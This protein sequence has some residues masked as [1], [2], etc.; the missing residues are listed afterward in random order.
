MWSDAV[1]NTFHYNERENVVITNHTLVFNVTRVLLL[2]QLVRKKSGSI[3]EDYGLTTVAGG[4][5][6]NAK[7]NRYRDILPCTYTQRFS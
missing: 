4:I 1:S 5:K 2:L 6:E 3:K 7:K